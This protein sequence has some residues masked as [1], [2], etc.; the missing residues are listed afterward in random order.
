[1]KIYTQSRGRSPDFEYC[2]LPETP[3]HLNMVSGLIQSESPSI[4][5]TRF[6]RELML[7]VTGMESSDRIDFRDRP[8][9][10]SVAWV[11]DEN[12]DNERHLRAIAIQALRG[13]LGS[14]IDKAIRFGGQNGFEFSQ[15]DIEKISQAILREEE[16]ES[17]PLESSELTSK[18]GKNLE[19]LKDDLAF[20]LQRYSLPKK[21]DILVVVTGNKARDT[22]VQAGAWRALSNL[23]NSDNWQPVPDR[24]DRQP[25]FQ[26]AVAIAVAVIVIALIVLVLMLHP[27]NQKPTV[28][29]T[30]VPTVSPTNLIPGETPEQTQQSYLT[31]SQEPL[32]EESTPSVKSESELVPS[33]D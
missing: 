14:E 20:R 25:N 26:V 22:F 5:I 17:Q 10:N 28:P 15:A 9:R 13:L 8:V 29:P 12:Y 4:V 16:L 33:A 21:Y 24:R 11:C 2:W 32:K 6:N 19:A 27:F 3:P 23:I 31:N 1:M 18:V 7:L 30:P